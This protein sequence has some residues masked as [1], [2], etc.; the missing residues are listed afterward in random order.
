VSESFLSESNILDASASNIL[1]KTNADV[2]GTYVQEI[3]DE[4]FTDISDSYSFT[5]N[6][7]NYYERPIESGITRIRWVAIVFAVVLAL[8]GTAL[9]IILGLKEKDAEIALITVRGFSKWQL[10]KTL[11]AEMLV[12]VL[13]ALLLGSLVG[14]IEIFGNVNL[15][16]QNA[17]GLIRT[18]MIVGGLSGITMLVVIGVVILAAALPVYW[19]SR[20]PESKVDVLRV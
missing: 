16:N 10:F 14:F 1:I 9:V 4:T 5:S 19:A 12:M 11:L 20:R 3:L 15:E 7:R 6:M 17:T 18:R 13:F 2:N 8:V